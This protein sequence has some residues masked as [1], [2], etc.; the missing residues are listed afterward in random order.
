MKGLDLSLWLVSH[1]IKLTKRVWSA[2]ILQKITLVF[3]LKMDLR[4]MKMSSIKDLL[5]ELMSWVIHQQISTHAR[6]AK[7]PLLKIGK[8]TPFVNLISLMPY[9]CT[10]TKIQAHHIGFSATLFLLITFHGSPFS[11][12]F[13]IIYN[14]FYW[15]AL[16]SILCIGGI[17]SLSLKSGLSVTSLRDAFLISLLSKFPLCFFLLPMCFPS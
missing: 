10:Q 11:F 13:L 3:L 1:L 16:L 8:V 4:R 2:S 15:N 5:P 14:S 17:S 7:D 6:Y 9:Q 12:F